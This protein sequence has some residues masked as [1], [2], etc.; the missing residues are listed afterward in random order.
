MRQILCVILVISKQPHLNQVTLAVVDL[1][2]IYLKCITA[3][4][5]QRCYLSICAIHCFHEPHF[6]NSGFPHLLPI[7]VKIRLCIFPFNQH[8]RKRTTNSR[9]VKEILLLCFNLLIFVKCEFQ[10][11]VK[12]VFRKL[13]YLLGSASNLKMLKQSKSRL[14]ARYIEK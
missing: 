1:L 5:Q 8:F 9:Q 12:A 6:Q 3:K 11:P 13:S 2:Q 10:S 14:S 4:F 7:S